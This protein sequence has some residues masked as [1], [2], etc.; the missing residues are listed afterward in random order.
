[1][2]E[3]DDQASNDQASKVRRKF[4]I[5]SFLFAFFV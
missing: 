5:I 3:A 2:R 1:M 4:I